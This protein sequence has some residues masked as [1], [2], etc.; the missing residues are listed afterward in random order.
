MRFEH[1][2]QIYWTKGF[3]YGGRLFYFDQTFEELFDQAPGLGVAS[4]QAISDRFELGYFLQFRR[5]ELLLN[6]QETNHT[7]MDRS[8]NIIFSQVNT[9]N[10]QR[11]DLHR[12][13]VIRLYLIKSYRGRC[14]ALGKPVRGQRTWSNAWGSYN[15]NTTLRGF[16]SE[17]RRL[18]RQNKK[19][20]KIN[21]KVVKKKY[22]SRKK[23]KQAT[24]KKT[25]FVIL[26]I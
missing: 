20:E 9:V 7:P 18:I 13:N 14:H 19:E 6:Y 24:K 4:K 3:F 2:L 25:G 22:A 17:M 12:L 8:I 5:K 16:V 1:I 10:N 11:N 15:T 21:Y 23:K 26:I